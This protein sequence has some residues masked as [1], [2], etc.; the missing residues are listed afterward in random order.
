VVPAETEIDRN[1]RA[2]SAKLRSAERGAG[3]LPRQRGRMGAAD[4][5]TVDHDS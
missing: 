3:P 2:R 1:P 5:P 4:T